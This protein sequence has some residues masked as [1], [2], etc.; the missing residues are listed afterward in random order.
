LYSDPSECDG[1]KWLRDEENG[2]TCVKCGVSWIE[3]T[4]GFDSNVRPMRKREAPQSKPLNFES[5]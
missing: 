4:R 3:W 5:A 1:H 2:D